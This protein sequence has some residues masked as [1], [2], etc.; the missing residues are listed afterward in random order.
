VYREG[1]QMSKRTIIVTLTPWAYNLL[2]S[3][4]QKEG[5]KHTMMS[6][7]WDSIS[8]TIDMMLD[9]S[10]LSDEHAKEIKD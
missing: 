4:L 3:L 9:T 2:F 10:I 1:K 6:G 7:G 5:K 8:K